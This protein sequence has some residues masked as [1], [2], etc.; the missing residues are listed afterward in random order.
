MNQQESNFPISPKN[1]G[2]SLYNLEQGL[3]AA[4]ANHE[5]DQIYQKV[6]LAY[7]DELP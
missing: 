3:F 4:W 6:M 1:N 7:L 5:V 2:S